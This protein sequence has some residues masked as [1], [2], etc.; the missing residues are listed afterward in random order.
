MAILRK[1]VVTQLHHSMPRINSLCRKD[2]SLQGYATN[3]FR[4]YQHRISLL[5]YFI[6]FLCIRILCYC[7]SLQEY[8]LL[9]NVLCRGPRGLLTMGLWTPMAIGRSGFP[10]AESGGG[11]ENQDEKMDRGVHWVE[12]SILLLKMFDR[13][14]DRLG[15]GLNRTQKKHF[16]CSP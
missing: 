10:E 5:L 11:P 9:G 14:S 8:W 2:I 6:S 13:V 12:I 16:L 15:C 1:V 3:S 4:K 7:I